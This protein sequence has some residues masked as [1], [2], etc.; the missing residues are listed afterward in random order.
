MIK[1][2]KDLFKKDETNDVFDEDY[3]IVEEEKEYEEILTEEQ[4]KEIKIRAKAKI[5]KPFFLYFF[6]IILCSSSLS[7]LIYYYDF[8][9]ILT[10]DFYNFISIVIYCLIVL[11]IVNTFIYFYFV[12]SRVYS[13]QNYV[14]IYNKEYVKNLDKLNSVVKHKH[15]EV[16]K[17][18]RRESFK[19][20]K[21]FKEKIKDLNDKVEEYYERYAD[22]L[23]LL[24]KTQKESLKKEKC[25][26]NLKK[27]IKYLKTIIV[28]NCKS[29]HIKKMNS[30]YINVNNRILD[31][32]KKL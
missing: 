12:Y 15:I 22:N 2:I 18:I 19:V 3:E 21:P 30:Y 6:F 23:K 26:L 24:E 27:H 5:N 13:T 1:F 20:E 17:Y 14:E 29:Y 11:I 28:K 16:D 10:T 32:R 8:I 31:K 9:N 7:Y 25:I 4:I